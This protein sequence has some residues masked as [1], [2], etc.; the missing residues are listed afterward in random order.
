MLTL[1]RILSISVMLKITHSM[2][3]LEWYYM[4]G[5]KQKLRVVP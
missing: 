2:S 3:V 5:F 4:M 1:L